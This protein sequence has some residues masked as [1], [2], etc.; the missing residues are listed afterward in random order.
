MIPQCR[1]SRRNRSIRRSSRFAAVLGV[2]SPQIV[3]SFRRSFWATLRSRFAALLFWTVMGLGSH[4]LQHE[5]FFLD[6]CFA[7]VFF[8]PAARLDG[9]QT[10]ALQVEGLLTL[11][12]G[13]VLVRYGR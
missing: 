7:F 4:R 10:L 8:G 2:C 11:L 3:I 1:G 5:L 9:F 12:L 6:F 13:K